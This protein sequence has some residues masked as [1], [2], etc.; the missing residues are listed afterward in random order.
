[1]R[2]AFAALRRV[3]LFPFSAGT[4][5]APIFARMHAAFKVSVLTPAAFC[6][7]ACVCAKEALIKR[8]S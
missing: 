8:F 2:A 1:M 6:C 7:Y 5:D 4:A 3:L